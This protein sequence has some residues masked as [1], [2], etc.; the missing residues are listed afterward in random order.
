MSL[1]NRTGAPRHLD[2]MTQE[3]PE[4]PFRP[5]TP[6]LQEA[7]EQEEQRLFLELQD[8]E[9]KMGELRLQMEMKGRRFQFLQTRRIQH[10]TA[11]S[12]R[13]LVEPEVLARTGFEDSCP[14]N[15]TGR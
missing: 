5:S 7:P 10:A 12:L 13:P 14:A 4:L 3:R 15:N 2:N 8:A 11:P 1:V 6:V 9:K